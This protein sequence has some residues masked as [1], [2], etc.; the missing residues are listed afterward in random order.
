M[1]IRK[2]AT[3][4]VLAAAT[5]TLLGTA[6]AD[7]TRPSQI[8]ITPATV[9]TGQAVTAD[10][11]CLRPAGAGALQPTLTS[12]GF[13][14]P[15]PLHEAGNGGTGGIGVALAGSGPAGTTPGR[16]TATYDCWGWIVHADFIV[17]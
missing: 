4:A 9:G 14:A 17:V 3:A 2:A 12:D 8:F 10:I 15:I 5:I 7:A 6:Q 16:Y 1:K 11:Y 13:A